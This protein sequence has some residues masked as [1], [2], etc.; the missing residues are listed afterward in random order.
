MLADF[1]DHNREQL[2]RSVESRAAGQE[3]LGLPAARRHERIDALVTEAT[4]ALQ[5]KETDGAKR[6]TAVP[7]DGAVDSRER[8]LILS[9]LVD[10]GDRLGSHATLHEMAAVFDWATR[11]ER[12]V[13]REENHRLSALLD[14]VDDPAT[15]F[16]T[17]GRILYVNQAAARLLHEVTGVPADELIGKTCAELHAPP[18]LG[19]GLPPDQLESMARSGATAEGYVWERWRE[20]R[21]GAIYAPDGMLSAVTL[22]SEDIQNRKLAQTRN[23]LLSKLAAL[24]GSVHYD[25]VPEALARVAVPEVADWCIV[26]VIED[27]AIRGTFV[28][29]RD[30]G[31]TALRDALLRELPTWRRH[32]LWQ[33]MLTGGFQLLTEVSDPMLRSLTSNEAQYRL[34][35]QVGARSLMVV[36]IVSRGQ[37]AGIITLV[38]T[39]ESGRRYGRHDP[40]LA[41][42]LA[43]YTAHIV[44]NARLLKE[45]SSSEAR[46]RVALASARTAVYEQDSSLRYIWY[47]NALVPFTLVGKKHEDGFPPDQAA[48]LNEFKQRVL[49]SGESAQEET[50]LTLG[51]ARRQYREAIE[52]V[53]DHA[54]KVVGVIGAATDITEE[55]RAQAELSRALAFR[56]QINGILGHDLRNP[57]SALTMATAALRRKPDMPADSRDEKLGVIQRAAGRMTE[58]IDTLLDFTRIQAQGR[59]PVSPVPLDLGTVVREVTDES[60][61]AFPGRTID[62]DVR[63]DLH[64]EWD[65]ARIAQALSNLVGN[66][67]AYGDPHTP[68]RVS[69]DGEGPDVLVKVSNEGAPIPPDLIPVFFEPFRRGAS[70]RSRSGLGLGLYIVKQI[71]LAHGGTIDVDS[72]A[73]NGTTFTMHLPRTGGPRE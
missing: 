38:Y 48:H 73:E 37:I 18:E 27:K 20:Q 65:P 9:E 49:K 11:A 57:L 61:S 67:I 28:A 34:L 1:I 36:P 60:R 66:A 56:D 31:K 69:A 55:K 21:F 47:H 2:V 6:S 24:V 42:E 19:G 22:V 44:E 10:L 25:N 63:G 8:E 16:A 29:Q 5:G 59:L 12:Q 52:P 15:A 71:V 14:V 50:D 41:E 30:A 13:L 43:L 72:T 54:G 39:A 3:P 40:A 23:Q 32:P 51:G 62:V 68:V 70:D 64:G 33:E 46:F 17:D 58:M 45:L 26:N 4:Q 53:R 7:G 35:A